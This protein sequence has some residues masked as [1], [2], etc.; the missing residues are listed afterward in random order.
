MAAQGSDCDFG[1]QAAAFFAGQCLSACFLLES[2]NYIEH[3]GLTR[4]EIAPGRYERMTGAHSWNANHPMTNWSLFNLG[5]H[6]SHHMME[7]THYEGLGDNA[8]TPQLPTGYGGMIVLA[9][10]PQL[11]RKVM[12]PRVA[13]AQER[14]AEAKLA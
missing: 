5:R 10:I 11:W 14:P 6:S 13:A 4:R 2:V 1:W 12:D 3:Y 8:Q 7:A 9:M